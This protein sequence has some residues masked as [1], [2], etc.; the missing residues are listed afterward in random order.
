MQDNHFSWIDKTQR[1]CRCGGPL[2]SKWPLD[3]YRL[4]KLHKKR[5]KVKTLRLLEGWKM[6]LE[7]TTKK[8]HIPHIINKLQQ[9]PKS[10]FQKGYK[11]VHNFCCL[12]KDIQKYV[13]NKTTDD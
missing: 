12:N 8:H 5:R 1:W 9:Q 4:E 3:I 6:G 7:P 13:N 10:T 11:Y 2:L